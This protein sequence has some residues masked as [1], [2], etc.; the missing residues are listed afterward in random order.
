MVKASLGQG[1]SRETDPVMHKRSEN[2][3]VSL[4]GETL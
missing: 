2:S 1:I 4:R 3:N